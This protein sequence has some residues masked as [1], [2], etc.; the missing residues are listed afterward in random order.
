MA[1]GTSRRRLGR[2]TGEC[3]F[4]DQPEGP[5][6]ATPTPPQGTALLSQSWGW[7]D[8]LEPLALE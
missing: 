7:G 1:E 3:H 5:L 4:Q 2:C 8:C 6:L